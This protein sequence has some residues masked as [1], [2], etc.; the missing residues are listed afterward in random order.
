MASG[1]ETKRFTLTGG[2]DAISI[3]K[4]TDSIVFATEDRSA[5]EISDD[6]GGVTS[7]R[8]K[9]N[10]QPFAMTSRNFG[11][12]EQVFIKGTASVVL[13]FMIIRNP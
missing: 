9:G 12:A 13:D 2:F 6:V 3:P 8:V 4:G 1:F 11:D 10:E 7:F 5:F